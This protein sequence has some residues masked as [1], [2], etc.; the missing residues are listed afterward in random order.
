M[1]TRSSTWAGGITLAEIFST[2]N[3]WRRYLAWKEGQVRD[4]ARHHVGQMLSCRTPRLGAHLY[5]CEGCGTFRIVPHSCKSPACASCGKVRTDAWCS[6]LLSDILDVGYRHLIFTIPWQLRLIIRDNRRL[7]NVMFRAAADAVSSLTA[8]HPEPVGRKGRKWVE[9]RWRR[10]PFCPGMI[11]VVHT[12]GSD[13]KWNPHIHLVLTAGGLSLDG[14][15]WV[16]APKRYLAPAPALA[17]EWKLRLIA[18]IRRADQ[19]QRLF[20]RRLRSDRRRRINLDLLLGHVR[21]QKWHILVGPSLRTADNAVRYACRY[22]KRPVIAEG[23]IKRFQHGYVTFQF[24]DYHRG[25]ERTFS[26]QPVLAFMDR[27]VQH[28]PERNFRQVRHYGLF[29][30]RTRKED[31]KRARQILAQRKRRRSKTPGWEQRRKAAGDRRPLSCPRCGSDMVFH[32]C[33]FGCHHTLAKM[34]GVAPDDQIPAQTFYPP[35]TDEE[36]RRAA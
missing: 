19:Q 26:K 4:S 32:S 28:L 27:L 13:L 7:L 16:A 29:S 20:R 21:K 30:P 34:A 14:Q 18:G 3:N 23:R 17:T 9:G 35:L 31:L 36:K 10:K 15:R 2:N 33:A 5:R 25:G 6:Q 1:A 22:T 11:A 8:G 24:K 12:F